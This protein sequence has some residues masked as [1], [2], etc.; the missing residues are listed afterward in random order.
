MVDKKYQNNYYLG[1]CF[2]RKNKWKDRKCID[3]E[4]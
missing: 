1:D 2:R 3:Y 4:K